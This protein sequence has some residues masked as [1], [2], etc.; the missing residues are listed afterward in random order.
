MADGTIGVAVVKSENVSLME[1]EGVFSYTDRR[2][3]RNSSWIRRCP[4]QRH[5]EG[6]EGD[7][8]WVWSRPG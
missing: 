3:G 6:G 2:I 8:C 7:A 1:T 5:V 4:H